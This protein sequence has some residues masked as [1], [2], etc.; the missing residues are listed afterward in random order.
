M[1]F[2]VEDKIV[3]EFKIAKDFYTRDIKQILSYLKT[4]DIK[5]GHIDYNN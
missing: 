4:K 1:D 5:V 3:I 2:V